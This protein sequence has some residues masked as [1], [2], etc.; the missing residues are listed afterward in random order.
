MLKQG[1]TVIECLIMEDEPELELLAALESW[2]GPEAVR[3]SPAAINAALL[4]GDV[5]L[6]QSF[7][8]KG[9]AIAADE[10]FHFVAEG[11]SVA[12]ADWACATLV[13]TGNGLPSTDRMMRSVNAALERCHLAYC[14]WVLAKLGRTSLKRPADE[15]DFG[16]SGWLFTVSAVRSGQLGTCHWQ[17]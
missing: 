1:H 14:E 3:S 7:L 10:V 4:R 11:G 17:S 5:L 2:V 15:V 12:A 6:A 8:D 9:F 13:S 16:A